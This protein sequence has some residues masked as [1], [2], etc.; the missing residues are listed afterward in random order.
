MSGKA[1]TAWAT[2]EK[3]LN[4]VVATGTPE[5]QIFSVGCMRLMVPDGGGPD[6]RVKAVEDRDRRARSFGAVADRYAR[7]RP[8]YPTAAVEW[9][10]EVAPGREVVDLAAGTGKLTEAI[11][12]SGAAVV[13]VEP[14]DEMRATL[15]AGL[16]D[17]EALAGTAESIPL[18]DC[19]R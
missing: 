14:D 1:C 12:E 15:R 10:L 2:S 8:G 19:E 7:A 6:G 16:P 5:D 3:I 17:V 11:V 13:A 9:L 4:G 18:P